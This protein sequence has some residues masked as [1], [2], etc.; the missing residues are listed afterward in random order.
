MRHEHL[1]AERAAD[2]FRDDGLAVAG[3]A[4]EE[5]RLAG[6][7]RRPELVEHRL[8]DDQLVEP[9]GQRVAIDIG[10]AAMQART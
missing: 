2:A 4:V 7:H 10:R 6:V 9:C 1:G 3:R 5:Q 8:V